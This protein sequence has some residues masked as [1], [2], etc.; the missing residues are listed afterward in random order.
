M[1]L[2][3][4]G[5]MTMSEISKENS[6]I[7]VTGKE[8]VRLNTSIAL[9]NKLLADSADQQ[10]PMKSV[11]HRLRSEPRELSREDIEVML[12]KYNFFDWLKNESGN[13]K[14]NFTDNYD[15]TITDSV[16]GLIWQKSGSEEFALDKTQIYIDDLNRRKF[17]GYDD[18]RL[19]TLEELAS[20]LENEKVD[21]LHI[22][23]LFDREQRLCWSAD[24]R[25]SGGAWDVYFDVGYV[26]WCNLKNLGYVRGVRSRTM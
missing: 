16:T 20:L 24:K 13:F 23:P 12:K 3:C 11:L 18:W 4:A 1:K 9:V 7:P 17:A 25:A 14:N 8:V 2:K 5:M 21:G 22:N 6:L 10:T 19:P 15:G 26:D